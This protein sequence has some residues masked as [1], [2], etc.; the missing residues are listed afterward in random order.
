M[1][2][3]K[4]YIL[5]SF[6]ILSF[7]FYGC[8]KSE[9]EIMDE[10]EFCEVDDN[11]DGIN[12]PKD[13]LWKHQVNC[14]DSAEIYSKR[15]S[16]I[17]IDVYY[18]DLDGGYFICYHGEDCGEVRLVDLLNTIENP[19][20]VYYWF[21]FK[22]SDIKENVDKSIAL[23]NKIFEQYKIAN[24]SV[25]ESTYRY[26]LT[27][28]TESGFNTVYWTP[29]LENDTEE[30]RLENKR[31]IQQMMDATGAKNLSGRY[32]MFPFLKEEFPNSNLFIWTNGLIT[33]ADKAYIKEIE[34]YP[35]TKVVLVDYT[36]PF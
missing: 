18:K 22:D 2:S 20:G 8:R 16:G 10:E 29:R 23:F 15:F 17:E 25:I 31:E 7:G 9:I 28:L 3:I 19:E 11:P 36:E 12:Y 24:N 26:A 32:T 13:K 33:E 21:D 14:L 6:V 1:N 5:L 27:K 34:A 30:E 35:N 4:I